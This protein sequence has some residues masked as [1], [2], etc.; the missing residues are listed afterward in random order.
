MTLAITIGYNKSNKLYEEF[1]VGY[2]HT[3]QGVSE[4]PGRTVLCMV[5]GLFVQQK[6]IR[7]VSKLKNQVISVNNVNGYAKLE[8][9]NVRRVA[10]ELL[11][12]LAD[13]KS[14]ASAEVDGYWECDLIHQKMPIDAF[15]LNIFGRMNT[16]YEFMLDG[17]YVVYATEDCISKTLLEHIN[18]AVDDWAETDASPLLSD[19]ET[20][21]MLADWKEFIRDYVAKHSGNAETFRLA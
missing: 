8:M 9:S 17:T 16:D 14:T 2:V 1:A 10:G 5:I 13:G 4:N 11:N 18:K 3:V 19:E 6:F 12:Q 20:A 15:I 7:S 21:E